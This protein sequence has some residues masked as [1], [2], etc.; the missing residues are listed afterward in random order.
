M[1]FFLNININSHQI[2]AFNKDGSMVVYV[3]ISGN[4]NNFL[5]SV[6]TGDFLDYNSLH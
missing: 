2:F 6:P 1:T 4:L 3:L 5:I